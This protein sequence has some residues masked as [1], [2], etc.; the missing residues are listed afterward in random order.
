MKLKNEFIFDFEEILE[1]E[2]VRIGNSGKIQI[3][4]KH[5]GKTAKVIIYKQIVGEEK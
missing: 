2:V 4:A 1:R 3:P 5:I